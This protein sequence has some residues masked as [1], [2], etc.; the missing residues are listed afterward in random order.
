MS[1]GWIKNS[2]PV[3]ETWLDF[4]GHITVGQITDCGRGL[5]S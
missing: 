3:E 5:V 4:Q 2:V 1:V